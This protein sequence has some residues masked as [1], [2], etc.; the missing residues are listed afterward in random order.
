MSPKTRSQS[1]T[2]RPPQSGESRHARVTETGAGRSAAGLQRPHTIPHGVRLQGRA[3][4]AHA[5]P[6]APLPLIGGV[7][8]PCCFQPWT[9]AAAPALDRDPVT[10]QSAIRHSRPSSF[11]PPTEGMR[12][13]PC[14]ANHEVST[15]NGRLRIRWGCRPAQ[16]E[17][18]LPRPGGS[19]RHTHSHSQP[20]RDGDMHPTRNP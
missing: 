18:A 3:P 12:Y 17:T 5:G 15:Q 6:N 16:E 8:N 9:A 2:G 1:S 14:N 7:G 19:A 10:S 4:A 11:L 13:S 20:K